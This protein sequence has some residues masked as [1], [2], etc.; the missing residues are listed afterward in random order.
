MQS[1]LCF[2]TQ[3]P[4]TSPFILP[5]AATAASIAPAPQHPKYVYLSHTGHLDWDTWLK[6]WGARAGLQINSCLY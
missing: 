6:A 2:H 4:S 3:A 1:S 5:R